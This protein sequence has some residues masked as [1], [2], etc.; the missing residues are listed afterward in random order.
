ML[1]V[2]TGSGRAWDTYSLSLHLSA[3]LSCVSSVVLLS[4]SFSLSLSKLVP[5]IFPHLPAAAHTCTCHTH[6]CRGRKEDICLPACLLLPAP[7]PALFS[8]TLPNFLYH[9]HTFFP[10]YHTYLSTYPC[11]CVCRFGFLLLYVCMHS[12]CFSSYWLHLLYSACMPLYGMLTWDWLFC[13]LPVLLSCTFLLS[14]PHQ[15]PQLLTLIS[16]TN[17][18]AQH[19]FFSGLANCMQFTPPLPSVTAFLHNFI[20]RIDFSWSLFSFLFMEHVFVL[21]PNWHVSFAMCF[22]HTS[23]PIMI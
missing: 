14:Y 4:W 18:H 23:D 5:S 13:L 10:L 2:G 8:A 15:H 16:L 12:V 6:H 19:T 7:L 9:V 21:Y 20:T 17:T 22:L 1:P 11:V 3:L